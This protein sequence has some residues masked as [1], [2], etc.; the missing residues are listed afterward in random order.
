MIIHFTGPAFRPQRPAG[1]GARARARDS[2]T[3]LK[4]KILIHEG[5][6]LIAMAI[7]P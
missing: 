5:L 2:D 3:K 6:V 4:F 1:E 7:K